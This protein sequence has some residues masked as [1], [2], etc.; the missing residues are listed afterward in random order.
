MPQLLPR[1]CTVETTT[2]LRLFEARKFRLAD[3]TILLPKPFPDGTTGTFPDFVIL[4]ASF[5][6]GQVLVCI[7]GRK[8]ALAAA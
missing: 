1:I 2:A 7:H 5:S 3:H 8:A 6:C 4:W